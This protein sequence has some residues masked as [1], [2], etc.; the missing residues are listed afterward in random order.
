ML[1]PAF[2]STK[3]AVIFSLPSSRPPL[4]LWR[5]PLLRL[6][7]LRRLRS[8][9]PRRHRDQSHH[10]QQRYSQQPVLNQSQHVRHP[11]GFNS[12]AA[13]SAVLGASSFSTI[14]S[15]TACAPSPTAP[16]PSSVGTPSADVK[17]PSDPPPVAA[18]CRPKPIVP[19]RVAARRNKR[20]RSS[21]PL[22]RGPVQSAL[23]C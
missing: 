9:P 13:S 4:S 17:F 10:R 23:H 20:H 15:C 2:A 5:L 16:I 11:S 19:A 3:S 7:A 12:I 1:A 18:S 21:R 6:S 22:H 14:D 8:R